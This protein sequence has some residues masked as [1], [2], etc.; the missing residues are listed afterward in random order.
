MRKEHE[1]LCEALVD[2]L[3]ANRR[4]RM[5]EGKTQLFPDA[6][7]HCDKSDTVLCGDWLHSPR[8]SIR[9]HG[10]DSLKMSRPSPSAGTVCVK[11]TQTALA[12]TREHVTHHTEC[13]AGGRNGPSATRSHRN[14]TTAPKKST[15][16]RSR[17]GLRR[18]AA[19]PELAAITQPIAASTSRPPVPV[20]HRTTVPLLVR[21]EQA[22]Q[23][24]SGILESTARGR[25][26]A[27]HVEWSSA[28]SD[29]L[30]PS[31]PTSR[32]FISVCGWLLVRTLSFR[33]GLES[34]TILLS[35]W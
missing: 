17:R 3:L 21:S 33:A 6:G 25:R 27:S 1:R 31:Q 2:S 5:P 14:Q 8:R 11:G 29:R 24:L 7:N 19:T 28:F 32:R 13:T 10:N 16:S 20:E 22:S 26:P 15:T 30:D 34:P 4:W 23:T 12:S 18:F 9:N 35:W